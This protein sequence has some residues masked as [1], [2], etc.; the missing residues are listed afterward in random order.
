MKKTYQ[1]TLISVLIWLI[2]FPSIGLGG[3]FVVSLIHGKTPAEAVQIIA[4]QMDVLIGRVETVE[5]KQIEQE[6]ITSDIQSVINQQQDIIE[7][8]KALILKEQACNEARNYLL[9]NNYSGYQSLLDGIS[10]QLDEVSHWQE[11]IERMNS[12]I[13]RIENDD[14][15]VI[16]PI[17]YWDPDFEQFEVAK[18][19]LETLRSQ[20]GS[21]L[22]IPF[23]N[24]SSNEFENILSGCYTS[25]TAEC[26]G[27]FMRHLDLERR[28]I[29]RKSQIGEYQS[30]IEEAIERY[31]ETISVK[32]QY[33]LLK[34]QCDLLSQ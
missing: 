1:K 2:A 19:E 30:R 31:N 21:D 29:E 4:E 23:A 13:Q 32:E 8:Q 12:E 24:I 25:L 28:Y 22:P 27:E 15:A 3:S 10:R 5:V 6:Q 17:H 9:N 33:L 34:Q 16:D 7:Q 18:I 26:K 20:R 11:N 14:I